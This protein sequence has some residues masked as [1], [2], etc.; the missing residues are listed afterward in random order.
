MGCMSRF[1]IDRYN[2]RSR[3]DREHAKYVFEVRGYPYAI[4][5]VIVVD[6]TP[7]LPMN[8]MEEQPFYYLYRSLEAAMRYARKIKVLNG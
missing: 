4:M 6:G 2:E 7:Q 5:E 8:V 3:W 1:L